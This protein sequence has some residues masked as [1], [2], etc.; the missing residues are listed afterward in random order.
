[1]F[2][3]LLAVLAATVGLVLLWWWVVVVFTLANSW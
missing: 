1:M 3:K 2:E